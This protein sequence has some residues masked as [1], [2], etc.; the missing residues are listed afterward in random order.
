MPPNRGHGS[1]ARAA[2]L[3]ALNDDLFPEVH[4]HGFGRPLVEDV[5]VDD[6]DPVR[7]ATAYHFHRTMPSGGEIVLTVNVKSFARPTFQIIAGHVPPEG[8]TL[9]GLDGSGLVPAS[10]VTADMLVEQ[11]YLQASPGIGY[12]PFR[13]P[14]WSFLVGSM[15]GILESV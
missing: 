2:L 7:H 1:V 4:R 12:A 5:E 6:V 15:G 9:V 11:A 10:R 3:H 13:Q 14:L 8:V